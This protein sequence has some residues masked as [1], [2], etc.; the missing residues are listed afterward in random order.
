MRVRTQYRI[1]AAAELIDAFVP[2]VRDLVIIAVG[3]ALI[4]HLL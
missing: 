4:V 2:M 1:K 3:I